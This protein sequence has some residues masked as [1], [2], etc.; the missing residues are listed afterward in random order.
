MPPAP[1]DPTPKYKVS[2]TSDAGANG[3]GI[4]LKG[5]SDKTFNWIDATDSWTS[6]EHIELAA[7]KNFRIDGV[8][9]LSKTI[10]GADV[11]FSSLQSVGTINTGVW[12]A[13]DIAVL[14]GGTGAS[15]A[16]QALTNLG[17]SAYAKT[18]IDDA[19][20]AA[21]RTTLGCGSIATQNANNVDID[22]GTIDGITFDM[23]TF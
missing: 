21:A 14:H 16:T 15:T 22:G 5:T 20:A 11:I 1:P 18:L 6:S 4:T 9:V 3:G 23:G 2:S 8:N 13:T 12:A 19:N 17:F 7:N 10:L